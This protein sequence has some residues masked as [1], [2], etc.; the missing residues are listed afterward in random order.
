MPTQNKKQISESA[1]HYGLK[2]KVKIYFV[3]NTMIEG[4]LDFVNRYEYVLK[5]AYRKIR[6]DSQIKKD[7][8]E[9]E[10]IILK[11]SVKYLTVVE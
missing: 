3:D 11:A 4:T 8:F 5:D 10:V 2:K 6:K 1:L 9:N 7:Q